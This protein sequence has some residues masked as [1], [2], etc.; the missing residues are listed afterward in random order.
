MKKIFKY[1]LGNDD[2]SVGEEIIIQMPMHAEILTIQAQFGAP[3][4]WA[5]VEPT[6]A[7]ESRTFQIFGTGQ[8]I[9][10]I[11]GVNRK[12]I[13]TYQIVSGTYVFHVFELCTPVYHLK[14]TD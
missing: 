14:D 3:M 9:P 1:A 5:L 13:G 10:E 2:Q 7:T 8:P 4:I 6:A 11:T 12:Y